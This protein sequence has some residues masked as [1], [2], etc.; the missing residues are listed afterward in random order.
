MGR[1]KTKVLLSVKDERNAGKIRVQ[2]APGRCAKPKDRSERVQEDLKNM[3]GKEEPD[4]E[5]ID[6]E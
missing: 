4:R 3:R 2:V 6:I 1:K 5:R